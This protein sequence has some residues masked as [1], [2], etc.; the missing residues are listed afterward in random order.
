MAKR[1][2][3][4]GIFIWVVAACCG[5]VAVASQAERVPQPALVINDLQ[6]RAQTPFE[7]ADAPATVLVFVAPDC[8]IS[9]RYA[10]E[11]Q[12]L[13]QTYQPRGIRFYLVYADAAATRAELETHRQTYKL[14]DFVA[15]HDAAHT[16]VKATG[17]TVTPEVAVIGQAGAIVYRGRIDNLYAALGK[18]RRQVTEH[19]LRAALD[20]L[21]K[22]EPVLVARTQALG[23]Y[24]AAQN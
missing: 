16:L 7:L 10:P 6:G 24:I 18:A 1:R 19:D 3:K 2:A 12:R 4:F 21:L 20:A 11:L 8:P 5:F 9:N 23:C 15:I 13:A 22:H 17:A 14:T